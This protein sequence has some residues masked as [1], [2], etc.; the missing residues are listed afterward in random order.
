MSDPTIRRVSAP[1]NQKVGILVSTPNDSDRVVECELIQCCHCQFTKP[2]QL[3]DEH[4]W[5]VCYRCNDWHCPKPECQRCVTPE[6][7]RENIRLG[8]PADHQRIIGR[9]EA[10]P[11]R[12]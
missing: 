12:D 3:G 6:Q 10:E 2:F 5:Q 1:K 7:R 9:V 4:R 11:P 8:R